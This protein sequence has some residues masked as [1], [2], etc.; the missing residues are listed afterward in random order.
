[1]PAER[2]ISVFKSVLTLALNKFYFKPQN[3]DVRLV[4]NMQ[5]SSQ[6]MGVGA[7]SSSGASFFTWFR[8]EAST[9]CE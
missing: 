3:T 1:M 2:K 9:K 4:A 5:A 6:R 7:A 8:I